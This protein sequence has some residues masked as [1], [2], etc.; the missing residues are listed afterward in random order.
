MKAFKTLLFFSFLIH[1]GLAGHAQEIN[2][3]DE[4]GKRHGKWTKKFEGT[5]QTRYEGVFSHGMETG[6]FKFYKIPEEKEEGK[7]YLFAT[8][9]YKDSTDLV[10]MRYF[11]PKG[12]LLTQGQ[13]R[14]RE[15]VG[16]WIYYHP[17]TEKTMREENY[18]NGKLDGLQ[19]TYFPNGDT[20]KS[21]EYENGVLNGLVKIYAQGEI[22]QKY[23]TYK[24]GELNGLVKYFDEKGNLIAEGN[25]KSNKKTGVWKTYENGGVVKTEEF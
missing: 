17:D 1:F 12:N 15:R 4:N 20:T 22:L 23:Y 10:E 6:T 13:V 11:T 18:V 9:T 5:D 3:F 14:N 8:K 16:K 25:Y 21:E 2:Q 7:A 19:T 24:N